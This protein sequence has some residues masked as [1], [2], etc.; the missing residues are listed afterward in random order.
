MITFYHTLRL[1]SARSDVVVPFRLLIYPFTCRTFHYRVVWILVD[2][3]RSPL[4]YVT[5]GPRYP[6]LHTYGYA[7]PRFFAVYVYRF[8][9]LLRLLHLR[10]CV[11]VS[12]H[13]RLRL[14]CRFRLVTF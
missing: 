1:R 9:L 10:C 7:L 4:R 3:I 8:A 14:I 11:Y 2:L 6:F 5:F 13:A 12:L